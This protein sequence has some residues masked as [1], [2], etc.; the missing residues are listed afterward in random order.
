MPWRHQSG[1]LL[2]FVVRATI[3]VMTAMCDNVEDF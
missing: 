3:V 1:E 2:L